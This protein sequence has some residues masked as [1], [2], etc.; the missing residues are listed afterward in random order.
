MFYLSLHVSYVICTL[1]VTPV[2]LRDLHVKNMIMWKNMMY[3]N[4][5]WWHYWYQL[6][7]NDHHF[8][9]WLTQ[10]VKNGENCI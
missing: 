5:P 2:Q 8:I 4:T 6:P 9:I 3:V 7:E 1:L 10:N